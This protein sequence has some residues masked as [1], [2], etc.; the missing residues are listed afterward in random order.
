MKKEYKKPEIDVIAF[1]TIG[2]LADSDSLPILGGSG[3]AGTAKSP[4]HH[5]YDDEEEEEMEESITPVA[6]K[7][8]Y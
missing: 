8:Y 2:A 4:R 6:R 5:L 7:K 1:S 3:S